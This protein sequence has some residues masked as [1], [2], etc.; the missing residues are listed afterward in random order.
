MVLGAAICGRSLRHV[1]RRLVLTFGVLTGLFAAGY[2]VMF[3]LLDDFRD[4]YGISDGALGAV[5]AVGFFASFAA[6]VFFAPLADRG[7]ARRLVY[8]GMALNVIGL[9]TMAFGTRFV[10]LAAARVIMGMGAGMAIPA[11]RR[12]VILAD[13]QH[14]G[15]NIGRLL[16]A[17]VAGFAMGPAVSAVLVGPLGIPGP[18]LTIAVATVLCIPVILRVDVDESTDVDARPARFAFDLLRSRGY[19]GALCL[20]AA[21][22]LMIGTFDALWVLVLDDLRTADWIANL[23][24]TLF[25]LPMIFLGPFGGRLAQRIGPF[26]LGSVGLLAGATFMFLYGQLPSGVAMFALAMVHS[27]NDG[28][29]ISAAGV[30]VG[31]VSPPE[32]Q[33]GA[34]GLL[35]GTQTLVGGIAAISAGQLYQHQGRQWAYGVCGVAMATL[36]GAALLLARHDLMPLGRNR[37]A[38]G[39]PLPSDPRAQMDVLIP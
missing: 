6:Q 24:I 35:G 9:V 38:G 33:A 7:H 11:I 19:L 26:R 32:R 27:V 31:M 29:T 17:D 10:V 28:T 18:F 37:P 1:T 3:T 34:Q 5:V 39:G 22:F 30:A 16:A 23:G 25:A 20:G 14:L 2:G 12:I 21:G 36:I 15:S 8:V 13:R 4:T